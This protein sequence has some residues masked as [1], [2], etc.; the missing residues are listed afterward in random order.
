MPHVDLNI[1]IVGRETPD[2]ANHHIAVANG[3]YSEL[4]IAFHIR[5]RDRIPDNRIVNPMNG[6]F[7]ESQLSLLANNCNFTQERDCIDVYYLNH[8][9]SGDVRGV[10]VRPGGQ[11]EGYR[12][13]A[14]IRPII[15]LNA[16]QVDEETLAHELGHALLDSGDHHNDN[17][18]L[19]SAGAN[20]TGSNLGNEQ[21]EVIS[22]SRYVRP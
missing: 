21:R 3:I 18:N 9:Y 11:P 10:T 22:A 16:V 8:F 20:R 5:H 7:Y 17:N 19:M 6:Q 12:G 15:V 4:G 1:Y 2:N 13:R 14:P